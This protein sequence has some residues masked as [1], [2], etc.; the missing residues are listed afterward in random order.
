MR[1]VECFH[2]QDPRII[3][4]RNNPFSGPSKEL[5]NQLAFPICF[6]AVFPSILNID[7]TRPSE[8]IN[9]YQNIR[10]YVPKGIIRHISLCDNLKYIAE[11]D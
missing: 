10:R 1:K 6:S 2:L 5:V 8:T 11:N 4:A 7:R 9:V 3:Q